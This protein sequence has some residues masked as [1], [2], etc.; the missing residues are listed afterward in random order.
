MDRDQRLSFV[1]SKCSYFT[2][3]GSYWDS[4]LNS[5]KKDFPKFDYSELEHTCAQHDAIIIVSAN[6]LLKKDTEIY[7][8]KGV[9]VSFYENLSEESI[10]IIQKIYG[11][12][13]LGFVDVSMPALLHTPLFRRILLESK[14][15]GTGAG[16]GEGHAHLGEILKQNLL[17]LQRVKKIHEKLVPIR[18]EKIK[19]ISLYSK[20]AA[21]LS[22]GGEF[23]DIK[24]NR[25]EVAIIVSC[26]KSYVTSSIV[27]GHFE[28]F[29]K[30]GDLSKAGFE[31]FLE[32]LIEE[33]R[34]LELID[35]DEHEQ[36]QLDLIT[37]NLKTFKFEGFHFGNGRYFSN[38]KRILSE[39][40]LALNENSFEDAYY[41]GYLKRGERLVFASPGTLQNF[42]AND[43][44]DPVDRLIL[45]QFDNGAREL[46]NEVFFQ[47]KKNNEEEF[48]QHDASLIYLEVDANAFIQI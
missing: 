17:E 23:F 40:K 3:D 16:T 29:Q 44:R 14:I 8:P 18:E 34:E 31:Y 45:E 19:G 39:N 36:L 35:R 25:N 46:L 47:L 32:E 43:E 21:G 33:C 28:N 38:G 20:F 15:L 11:K 42:R 5:L 1:F 30:K 2:R 6:E 22:S 37:L 26:T 48:L 24:K 4:G 7:T 13:L 27:L 41:E 9:V 12:D 10:E